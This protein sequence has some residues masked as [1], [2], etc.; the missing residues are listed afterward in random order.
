MLLVPGILLN[1]VGILLLAVPIFVQWM[2][3]MQFD[4]VFVLS[5]IA[6][7]DVP[8]CLGRQHGRDADILPE[9]P[10]IRSSV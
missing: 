5:G 9:S 10:A 1:Q 8:F 4:G 6:P 7:R 2:Q 3:S